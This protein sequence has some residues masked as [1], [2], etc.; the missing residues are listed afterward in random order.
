MWV[1][2]R[3]TSTDDNAATKPFG[4]VFSLMFVMLSTM[5]VGAVGSGLTRTKTV[6]TGESFAPSFTLNVNES[7]PKKPVVGV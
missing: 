5:A 7:F 2:S 6:P 1:S 4:P 3:F